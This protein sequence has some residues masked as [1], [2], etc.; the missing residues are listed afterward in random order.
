M[1][2][3]KKSLKTLRSMAIL[4]GVIATAVPL[5]ACWLSPCS[6][7]PRNPCAA[8]AV[9]PCGARLARSNPCAPT[10]NPCAATGGGH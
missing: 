7:R 1:A 3:I 8:R 4:G 6:A 5:S 2:D 10:K 9:N